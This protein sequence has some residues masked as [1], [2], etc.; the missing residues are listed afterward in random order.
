MPIVRESFRA[1]R[2]TSFARDVDRRP[3]GATVASLE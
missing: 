2:R 3:L 1:I